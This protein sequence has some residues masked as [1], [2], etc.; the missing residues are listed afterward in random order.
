[1]IT[2]YFKKET[3]RER[4]LREFIRKQD[5][6]EQEEKRK[7]R[8]MAVSMRSQAVVNLID[9]T[10]IQS[11]QQIVS[12]VLS[13]EVEDEI[14]LPA[15]SNVSV[16]SVSLTNVQRPRKKRRNRQKRPENW[17]DI[18]GDHLHSNNI[19]KTITKFHLAAELNETAVKYWRGTLSD[20]KK[21]L[22]QGKTI[23]KEGGAIPYGKEI[24]DLL[25]DK[26]RLYNF[27]GAPINDSTLRMNLIQLLR[28]KNRQDIL[29]QISD[30]F[31]RS[32]E[33][34]YTFGSAW[35]QRFWK[36]HNFRSRKATTKMREKKI[37]EHEAKLETY[38]FHLSKALHEH[39]VPDALV[40]GFDET[41]GQFVP[42][43]LQ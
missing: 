18:I 34:K 43:F 23:F 41:S 20:W 38:C 22:L 4:D 35:A 42:S 16:A 28:E 27:H 31:Q 9:D 15:C 30:T 8:E 5:F 10:T 24:D 12:H 6:E 26:V 21:D 37:P 32:E 25:A 29:D 17:R 13:N 1:M 11:V 7:Q 19:V 40:V 36:R 39:N 14:R 3:P 33:K 2:N